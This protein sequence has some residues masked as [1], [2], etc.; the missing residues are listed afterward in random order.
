MGLN[1]LLSFIKTKHPELI[2]EEHISRFARQRVFVD[3]ASYLYKYVC[4]HGA[5]NN[6]WIHSVVGLISGFVKN[7]VHVIPVFDGKAPPEKEDERQE[8][9]EKRKKQLDR[10]TT[11]KKAID[12]Y[13]NNG[14]DTAKETI[15]VL[16]RELEN[17]ERKG[18]RLQRL[19]RPVDKNIIS[20][21]DLNELEEYA[22]KLDAG[23]EGLAEK[24][25]IFL[26]ALL[27]AM[28]IT[29]LDAPEESEAYCSFLV[30]EG[31]GSAVVSCD[32]DCIAH[33]ADTI[34]FNVES[35]G[36]ITVLE[37]DELLSEWELEAEQL[38]DFGILIGCDYNKGSR[39]N[40]IGPVKALSLLRQYQCIENIPNI[41]TEVLKYEACR[42]LFSPDYDKRVVV[43]TL[44]IDTDMLEELCIERGLNYNFVLS[45]CTMKKQSIKF[46]EDKESENEEDENE[47]GE[48]E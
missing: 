37:L 36:L 48:S 8:R 27:K 4:I 38:I 32:T 16:K 14:K 19:L 41:N 28:G 17:L 11:L 26:K 30:R 29:V 12:E 5:S 3:I 45:S 20:D 7:R 23:T 39:V 24:D 25:L 43:E 10:I 22:N 18:N 35:S 33:R 6:R 31:V 47:C 34:V 15:D 42:R 9:K 21:R 40:K 2:K 44:S 46:N 13:R 1:G